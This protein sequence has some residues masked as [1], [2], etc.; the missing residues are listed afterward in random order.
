MRTLA[1][2]LLLAAL[3]G[4]DADPSEPFV[5]PDYARPTDA[6][7]DARP[8]DARVRLDRAVGPDRGVPDGGPDQG[9]MGDALPP[10]GGVAPGP[11]GPDSVALLAAR[12]DTRV[13]WI[14]EGALWRLRIDSQG[15]PGEP[16]RLFAVPDGY[17]GPLVGA[18]ARPEPIW[19]VLADGP[20]DALRA[21]DLSAQDPTPI[22]TDLYLPARLAEVNGR[23]VLLGRSAPDAASALAWRTLTLPGEPPVV[24][25][26]ADAGVDDTPDDPRT[27][28]TAGMHDPRHLTAGLAEFVLGFD[29]GQCAAVLNGDG[30]GDAWACGARAGARAMGAPKQLYFADLIDG[31][32]VTWSGLPGAP[33]RTPRALTPVTDGVT[34]L[35][36][37]R[38]GQ[39]ALVGEPDGRYLWWFEFDRARRSVAP[40][41]DDTLGAT[42]VLAR[43]GVAVLL[44]WDAD[45][46]PVVSDVELAD[47]PD[48]TPPAGEGAECATVVLPEDCGPSDLD[49][50]GAPANG[51][52]CATNARATTARLSARV[53]GAWYAGVGDGRLALITRSDETVALR[54]L[55]LGV[56][57]ADAEA[58]V[59]WPDVLALHGAANAESRVVALGE[60]AT[61]PVLLWY[62]GAQ[63][64]DDS[65]SPP[66]GARTAIPC[67]EALGVTLRARGDA[68]PTARVFCRDTAYDVAGPEA[69]PVARPYPGDP[70]AWVRRLEDP[71]AADPAWL[72]ATGD[73]YTLAHWT[74]GDDGFEALD[75]LPP[76]VEPLVDA[77]PLAREYPVQPPV[78][79]GGW[80]ARV[81]DAQVQVWV[82]GLGWWDAPGS[83]WPRMA[84]L[85]AHEPVALTVGHRTAADASFWGRPSRDGNV[86]QWVA[87]DDQG[88]ILGDYPVSRFNNPLPLILRGGDTPELRGEVIR[89]EPERAPAE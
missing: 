5:P 21:Y 88:T 54:R 72:V 71:A 57:S 68:V 12:G 13:A 29:S 53:D 64:L 74:W 60:A 73:A 46:R 15:A 85:S 7:G 9:P 69:E 28:D 18:R 34:W 26:D 89:C 36:P 76:G 30:L 79:G 6:G 63:G 45:G 11:A 3:T 75:A 50:D 42:Y 1:A 58:T 80:A 37:V 27:L 10:D 39:L 38:G 47:V 87:A 23:V 56:D 33:D 14:A 84:S 48:A 67:D 19:V 77:S 17:T 62:V 83:R 55:T 2:A 81:V 82:D 24:D 8:T 43:P 4:C 59:E 70:V 41:A 44:R 65:V 49:C 78:V 22:D 32:L 51:R 86:L 16:E 25:P 66:R 52:C 40:V 35:P 20:N 31:E 61:G